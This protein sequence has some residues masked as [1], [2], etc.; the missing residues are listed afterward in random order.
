MFFFLFKG[1][2]YDKFFLVKTIKKL[3]DDIILLPLTNHFHKASLSTYFLIQITSLSAPFQT[4]CK[5]TSN[6]LFGYT[7]AVHRIR[8]RKYKIFSFL[9][10]CE[11]SKQ[12]LSVHSS[13]IKRCL[14]LEVANSLIYCTFRM[15]YNI[16]R[17]TFTKRRLKS[18][19][20]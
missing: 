4:N 12:N 17:T 14:E 5:L 15:L 13:N 10:F 7:P 3:D 16:D 20:I 19:V 2:Y 18:F 9:C 11:L 6:M 1:L 8:R